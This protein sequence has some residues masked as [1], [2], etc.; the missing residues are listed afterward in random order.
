MWIEYIKLKNFRQFRDQKIAFA[1][2]KDEKNIT[3]IE[4]TTDSGKSTLLNAITWCL[5]GEEIQM[6]RDK[7]GYPLINMVTF[8]EMAPKTS[9]RVEV[10]IQMR[11]EEN[12][13][14]IFNR[15]LTFFKKTDG[16]LERIE[17]PQS[18]GQSNGPEGSLFQYMIED[19]Y[20]Y[21]PTY[22]LEQLMPSNIREYF[23][24]DGDQLNL[25][26]KESSGA[27]I[28]QAVFDISQ[29]SLLDEAIKRLKDKKR[30]LLKDTTSTENETENSKGQLDAFISSLKTLE[31]E[32]RQLKY[33]RHKEEEELE[34]VRK[35]LANCGN[36]DIEKLQDEK[37]QL[38]RDI[39]YN[40]NRLREVEDNNLDNLIKYALPII[41]YDKLKKTYDLIH[42]IVAVGDIPSKYKKEVLKGILEKGFCICGE[43]LKKNPK[44]TENISKLLDKTSTLSDIENEILRT[45]GDLSHFMDDIESFEKQQTDLSK[46][47]EELKKT[48]NEKKKR[49]DNIV[50]MIMTTNIDNIKKLQEE[51]NEHKNKE[52]SIRDQIA[53]KKPQV[54]DLNRRIKKLEEDIEESN[55]KDIRNKDNLAMI[56]FLKKSIDVAESIKENTMHDVRNKIQS[57]TKN[58]FFE[59]HW[60]KEGYKDVR[61]NENYEISVE[62]P[63]GWETIGTIS[64]GTRQILALSFLAAL[65]GVSGFSAPIVIDTPLGRIANEP[66]SNIAKNLHKFLKGRQITMLMTDKE[67]SKEIREQLSSRIGKE[68]MIKFTEYPNGG[69]IAEVINYEK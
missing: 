18:S 9:E 53:R 10:E 28:K 32:I 54:D 35:E 7:K 1:S 66:S 24:F 64:K 48:Y 36:I 68:Y 34:R 12:K 67:Y 14:H 55:K 51:E 20:Q 8:Y 26:F 4:G 16:Q 33:D 41:I 39:K 65:N 22:L 46:N 23:F 29:I 27:N 49:L 69:G 3:I 19:K 31:E 25:Y 38:E 42:N 47:I 5:Y 59:L 63:K 15:H 17:E 61:I 30:E 2:Q 6:D 40:K 57:E 50:S 45:K 56:K 60:K 52:D 11:D 13:K 58:N 43:D 62:D 44:S 21:D 37:T